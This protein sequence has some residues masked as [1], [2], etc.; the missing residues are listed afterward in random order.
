MHNPQ[1]RAGARGCVWR[2]DRVEMPGRGGAPRLVHLSSV[3]SG[4]RRTLVALRPFE[5]LAPLG[6][7]KDVR[8]S[9]RE[10]ASAIVRAAAGEQL[11]FTA[12]AAERLRGDI[13]PW[14]LI[15]ALAFER[16][17]PRVLVADAAGMGKTISAAIAIAQC[18]DHGVDRRCLVLAPAHLVSQ[19]R[20]ELRERMGIETRLVD[21]AALRARRSELP[22]GVSPWSL[23]GCHLASLDFFKQPHILASLCTRLWDLIVIDEAHLACGMSER[24][25]A[26]QRIARQA[27]RVLLLT[28][29]PSDGGDERLRALRAL[30]A[31]GGADRLIAVRHEAAGGTRVERRLPVEPSPTCRMLH[32]RLAGY[33]AWI[34]SAPPARDAIAL[35]CAVLTKR[36]VS[37]A[38]AVRLTLERRLQL[39]ERTSGAVQPSLFDPDEDP[40]VLGAATGQP[41]DRERRQL[42]HLIDLALR[43]EREDRRLQALMKLVRRA[44]EPVL[45]FTCFRDT[46]ELLSRELGSRFVTRVIH[47]A[48]PPATVDAAIDAFT[49]GTTAVLVA[50]DVAAQG[51]NLQQRCRWVVHY[52]VP[53]RPPVIEQRT[54]RVDR[55]GQTRRVHATFL[56]DRTALSQDMNARVD[57]LSERMRQ[58]ERVAGCRWDVLASREAERLRLRRGEDRRPGGGPPISGHVTVIELECAARS[59]VAVDRQIIAL[60]ADR[61]D[62]HEWAAVAGARRRQRLQR[63]LAMRCARRCARERAIR[64]AASEALVRGPL[65]AGLFDRRAV[66]ARERDAAADAALLIAEADAIACYRDES[67]ISTVSAATIAALEFARP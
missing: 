32:E 34:A 17:F 6:P 19:W 14:Q 12:A 45:V 36:A 65:Q 16:G 63:Q 1:R 23:P 42:Q 48:L 38:H 54:G 10:A 27:R 58:D 3:E 2:I 35:L 43:A 46:A 39:L 55:L 18:L 28:A 67:E 49:R 62:A 52:D 31:T 60:R 24:H 30:G 41:I 44:R 9:A 59:G 22:A 13:H 57:A 4:L 64:S 37:S 66:R 53:W 11:A 8:V 21:A 7:P 33:T 5:P 47:G 40:A 51:L 56:F 29:T 61:R 20:E 26:V 25:K 15:A 50:T